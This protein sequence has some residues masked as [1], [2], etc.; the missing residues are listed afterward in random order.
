MIFC[1]L[2][3]SFGIDSLQR[4]PVEVIILITESLN[5]RSYKNTL[6]TW[7]LLLETNNARSSSSD[8]VALRE[9]WVGTMLYKCSRTS[10]LLPNCAT[11]SNLGSWDLVGGFAC[12][13]VSVPFNVFIMAREFRRMNFV[14][15]G[16]SV[17]ESLS[18]IR[19][20][21]EFSDNSRQFN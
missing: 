3:F 10:A 21:F 2:F 17:V 8:V 20:R 5:S 6:S 18:S 14:C 7:L 1:C 4:L 11:L 13:C 15:R 12:V 9:E 19:C 16:L